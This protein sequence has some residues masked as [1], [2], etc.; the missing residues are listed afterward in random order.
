MKQF[1]IYSAYRNFV[2]TLV[3]FVINYG[4]EAMNEVNG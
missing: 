2:P 1:P 4:K 3:A